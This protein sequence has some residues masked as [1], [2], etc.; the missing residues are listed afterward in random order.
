[1]TK[2]IK[3]K[4][5]DKDIIEE[6]D[7]GTTHYHNCRVSIKSNLRSTTILEY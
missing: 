4:E 5:V 2:K 3:K 6:E 7:Y 1:M